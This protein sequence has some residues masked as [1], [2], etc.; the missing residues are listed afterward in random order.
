MAADRVG[1]EG[2]AR[3]AAGRLEIEVEH[4]GGV[5]RGVNNQL[6][7]RDGGGTALGAH[8]IEAGRP[9]ADTAVGG[10]IGTA[11]GRGEHAVTE[12]HAAQCD[13]FAQVGILMLHA[14]PPTMKSFSYF[15]SRETRKRLEVLNQ[16][17]DGFYIAGED[18]KLR[19]PGDLFGIRQSGI[20]EFRLGD[21]FQDADILKQAN[22]AAT[23]ILK[24]DPDLRQP[25]HRA[26]AERLSGYLA[27]GGD[28][29]SL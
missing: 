3:E 28:G 11:H 20:L 18:L 26:L 1:Q 23:Q 25:K 13:G 27:Q 15:E 16:S 4:M 7:R 2:P 9:G 14:N 8:L 22:E 21:V 10:D 6:A 24:E 12:G 5:C 29:L 19:G 17:N